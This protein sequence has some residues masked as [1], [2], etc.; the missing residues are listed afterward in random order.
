MMLSVS[1]TTIIYCH[2]NEQNKLG[3]DKTS[4]QRSAHFYQ[5]D[6]KFKVSNL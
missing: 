1:H 4:V 5:S 2:G 3:E 6:I